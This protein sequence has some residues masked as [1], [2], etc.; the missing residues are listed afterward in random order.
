MTPEPTHGI[1]QQF[2]RKNPADSAPVVAFPFA[3]LPNAK[4]EPPNS[5]VDRL[6]NLLGGTT[7][8][9]RNSHENDN[10]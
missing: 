8:H 9:P 5:P 2:Q 7:L 1:H 4:V 3:H 6:K 10:P